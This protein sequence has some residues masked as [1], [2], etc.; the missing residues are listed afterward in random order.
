M[1]ILKPLFDR[2]DWLDCPEESGGSSAC[3]GTSAVIR[4]S[5]TLFIFHLLVLI[6]AAP[7]L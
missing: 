4:M 7:R 5:F 2:V 3:F 1:F 6:M